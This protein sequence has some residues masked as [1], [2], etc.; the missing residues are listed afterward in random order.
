MTPSRQL[1][2]VSIV[3]LVIAILEATAFSAPP[4]SDSRRQ[5]IVQAA[6]ERCDVFWDR[7]AQFEP[8]DRESCRRLFSTA[9]AF[10][11]ARV[12]PERLDR[13]FDLA[14]QMQ[15]RDPASPG[16]GNL[17][18]YW[19]DETVTDR[20]AVEFC[21]ED[22]CLIWRRHR[23][24]IPQPAREKLQ[25]LIELGAQG[26]QR[27]RVPTSYTNIALLNAS[28]LIQLGELL[29][30]AAVADDGY[31][32]L[33]A[34]VMWT[35]QFG[36]HEY[37]SPTYYDPD[38][39]GLMWIET[40]AER[41]SGRL[42][43]AALTDLLWTDIAANWYAAA[44][45]IAGPQ[46]RSYDYLHGLGGLQRT[47]W[48]NGW[49]DEKMPSPDSLLHSVLAQRSPA[50]R[51]LQMSLD[52]YPRTVRQS[53]GESL[54]QSRTHQM[55]RDITLG[56]SGACYGKQD[57]PMT[58]DLPGSPEQ[59]HCYFIADGREDPYGKKKYS[60]G[61]AGHM[62]ALHLTPLWAGAQRG[63]DA[64]GVAV[65]RKQDLPA[66]LV[67]NLQSHFVLRRQPDAIYV[68]GQTVDL[69][70][71]ESGKSPN[72]SIRPA[73]GGTP[74]VLRYGTACLGIRV[75]YCRTQSNRQCEI[76][77]VDDGRQY[78][79]MRL[80][81]EHQ[82]DT[83][84]IEPAVAFWVRIGSELDEQQFQTWRR[85]FEQAE[86]V[87]VN[88]LGSDINVAVPGLDGL[89]SVKIRSPQNTPV[90]RLIPR[91]SVAVLELDAE[92][93]GAPLLEK[94][95]CVKQ[96]R[97]R[98]DALE[99]IEVPEHAGVLWEA[100]SGMRMSGACEQSDPLASGQRFLIQPELGSGA[101]ISGTSTWL[102]NVAREDDYRL[103]GRV[104]SPTKENDS[105]F[106]SIYDEAGQDIVA[107]AAWHTGQA[108]DWQW[109]VV[110]LEKSKTPAV[111]HLKRGIYRLV[112][113]SREPGTGLDQLFLS[114]S[115]D[116]DPSR[117]PK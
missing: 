106:L 82:D 16:Y 59:T 113:A 73:Q 72:V 44:A 1:V 97:A 109:R 115:K 112:I 100:E 6:A 54:S 93:V 48:V 18:W 40:Y 34:M 108:S 90:V 51:L 22:A 2:R 102:L 79:A 76:N 91:P 5:V 36:T 26:C 110:M 95:E 52:R 96:F 19:G 12:H 104:L 86:P 63:N 94:L 66:S 69:T 41:S 11:E 7:I 24:W 35:W 103:W 25:L 8:D 62:K 47:L 33:E 71:T 27:H 15:D 77:L 99:P 21:M 105:F 78:G 61:S 14:T 98:M 9:L 89:V 88:T 87:S 17:R 20:N 37:C 116:E 56:T 45:R 31:R 43:A 53:W 65:Y 70:Q 38:L 74:L 4:L 50:A 58:I 49:I 39:S 81:V 84:S 13:L 68:D 57:L 28:N 92:D 80:T 55:Y 64:I 114:S 107:T 46:S 30:T 101:N 3:C 60:A 67:T 117:L 83:Q 23:D 111:L 42:Q 85:A 32:R 29:A 10:C 75:V